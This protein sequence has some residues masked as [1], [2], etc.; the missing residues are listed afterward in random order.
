M[1][2]NPHVIRRLRRMALGVLPS[3]TYHYPA[4]AHAGIRDF[5]VLFSIHSPILT[6]HAGPPGT[7]TVVSAIL[8]LEACLFDHLLANESSG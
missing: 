5:L 7:R 3:A 1:S 8:Y 4:Q 2:R 6:N